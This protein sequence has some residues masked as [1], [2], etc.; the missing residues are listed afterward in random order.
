[1]ILI[2]LFLCLAVFL[3]LAC[4]ATSP[5]GFGNNSSNSDDDD[6]GDDDDDCQNE[7]VVCDDD[8]VGYDGVN[9][10]ISPLPQAVIVSVE[11]APE[12]NIL[13]RKIIVTTDKSCSLSGYVETDGEF[14]YSESSPKS[15]T[16]GFVHEFWFYGLLENREFRYTFYLKDS[17]S[18]V[19][20]RNCFDTPQIGEP[21]PVPIE[22][23][24]DQTSDLTDWFMVYYHYTINK[25]KPRFNF[26]FDREGR[27]RFIHRM[28]DRQFSQAM[29]SGE[30]VSNTNHKLISV[31]PNGDKYTLFDVALKEP[32]IKSTHHKF[33]LEDSDA[34]AAT[35]IFARFGPGVECDLITPTDKA[36]GDGIAEIDSN[37]NEIWS[38]SP[39]D[40]L[41]KIPPEAVDPDAC[42][43]YFWGQGNTDWTHGNS[44]LPVPGENAYIVSLRNVNRVVKIDRATGNVIWQMGDGL[45]FE[46][47]GDESDYDK[48]FHMQHDAKLL[49]DGRFFV[50]DNSYFERYESNGL[51]SRAMELEVDQINMTVELLW[52]YRVPHH[53]FQ[54]NTEIH[55][56]GNLLVATGND[57]LVVE[58]PPGGGD[59]DEIFLLR[60]SQGTTRAQYYKPLWTYE[61][62]PTK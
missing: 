32:V 21:R 33:F 11:E 42:L 40:H 60:Y 26:I 30:I 7:P 41:D 62:P 23:I 17:P 52:E 8:S 36:I 39:F 24:P 53:T 44:V 12:G 14:G 37:G 20:A 28:S 25:E 47:I 10:D 2:L 48:W 4:E 55:E 43:T 31:K 49:P 61:N 51:F 6:S 50:Y 1:M 59:G 38:W 46:W 27:I 34:G 18:Q 22:V 56:N 13:A 54:G 57:S 9:D 58:L 19:V 16:T 29:P 45:D 35:V 15:S 5:F 3:F